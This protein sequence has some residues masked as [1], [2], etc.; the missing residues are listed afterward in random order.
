MNG[1]QS[2]RRPGRSHQHACK[3]GQPSLWAFQP[4]MCRAGA[5]SVCRQ[6]ASLLPRSLGCNSI[7]GQPGP[8]R[9]QFR[10]YRHR[11]HRGGTRSADREPPGRRLLRV[12]GDAARE[13][14]ASRTQFNAIGP[15]GSNGLN[16]LPRIDSSTTSRV[17][18]RSRASSISSTSTDG[19]PFS[20]SRT[21]GA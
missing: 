8:R 11:S 5:P 12:D 7:R 9:T 2:R 10:R 21:A 13:A 17:S 6:A 3:S 15:D 16:R 1:P 20:A 4:R 18:S 14:L 19:R